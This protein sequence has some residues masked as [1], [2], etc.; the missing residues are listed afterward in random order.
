MS[1]A[2]AA[3]MSITAPPF[4]PRFR[5]AR[6]SMRPVR[7]CVT[8]SI[9]WQQKIDRSRDNFDHRCFPAQEFTVNLHGRLSEDLDPAGAQ[10]A[11]AR[12]TLDAPGGDVQHVPSVTQRVRS[13]EENDFEIVVV[14]RGAGGDFQVA[15]VV[16]DTADQREAAHVRVAVDPHLKLLHFFGQMRQ[17]G[18]PV[19]QLPG[20][21]LQAKAYF[22]YDGGV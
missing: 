16:P 3:S 5:P 8:L 17:S 12:S 4:S 9:C 11:N 21:V 18:S 7:V 10:D 19:G 14:Q 20:G 22:I 2:L 13:L 1:G 6:E 15:A